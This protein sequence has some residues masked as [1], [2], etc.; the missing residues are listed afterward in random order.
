MA[1]PLAVIAA[2]LA[3]PPAT[4]DLELGLLA[5]P[6]AGQLRQWHDQF[7]SRPHV[8]GTPGDASVIAALV[9][10]FDSMGLEVVRDDF[11]AWMP[12]PVGAAVEIVSPVQR[13][14]PLRESALPEDPDSGHPELTIG[15]NAYSA[16]GD[17]V[18]EVVYANYGTRE[19]FLELAAMGVELQGRIVVARYGR[20]FRGH[21]ARFAEA[22]GAA[23]LLLYT[24]PDDSGYRK[25][26]PYP[27]GG[28]ANDGSI[29][30]G[31]I[32]AL[33]Y[34]GDPLT[35][36]VAATPQAE[37]LDPDAVGL[38]R[39]PVQPLGWAAAA[40]ILSRMRGPAVPAGWQG[41]LP[42]AY[43]VT[44]GPALRVR[45]AVE[46]QLTLRE[47][48]NVLGILRGATEPQRVVVV[49]C[50]HDAWGFGAS[51]P[52]AGLIVLME[53]ARSFGELAAAGVRPART[54]VFAA[55]GAEE[56]GIIGSVE[57]CEA[58]AKELREHAVAYVNLDM[59]AMGPNFGASAAPSL[60]RVIA[61]AARVVAQ[62]GGEPGE[63]VYD[64]WSA[65]GAEDGL[66][67]FGALGGGSD[68]VGFYCHLGV[69][70]CGLG[71]GGADGTAYHTNYDTLRWYRQVV[72]DSYEPALM[73]A[74][75]TN[76]LVARLATA[77][78]LPLDPARYAADL[79]AN[80]AALRD[81]AAATGTTADLAGLAGAIEDL[82]K[83]AQ[84]VRTGLGRTTGRLDDD[85]IA[86]INTEL[87]AVDRQWLD[88]GGLPQRA[89]FRNLYA[90]TD[91][92]SGYAA[93]VLPGL[94]YC[95]EAGD[96]A[97][98]AAAE[99]QYIEVVRSVA[100]R[101]RAIERMLPPT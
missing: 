78:L 84:A 8:A 85:T 50:H 101:L 88:D 95:V 82:D 39:I 63:T 62:A 91:P 31:S 38:P 32:K 28:W 36:F 35:P 13:S 2:T 11:R 71:A 33:P 40:E 61:D 27:E 42:F 17:A 87:M 53:C 48:A 66:P 59:A 4:G 77:R 37:R 99:Q 30:R 74:R 96:A 21:K 69:P 72:G 92:D 75:L 7:A 56:P 12:A 23:A 94:R 3:L 15:W 73:L 83:A 93:W 1:A 9:D 20:C 43:R 49:G 76:A 45:V 24:D 19:D 34:P 80:L 14:L 44:G 52:T 89:W 46:H 57:W 98:L 55:W 58:H 100:D 5:V 18:G 6:D 81:R 79:R 97:G 67:P 70:S 10:A 64:R 47:T 90:A 29:E 41:G 65:R 54:I 26:I 86:A 51:D 68:H 60:Q 22:A 25:G 16:S